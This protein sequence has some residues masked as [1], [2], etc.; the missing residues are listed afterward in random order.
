MEGRL[1]KDPDVAASYNN[2]LETCVTKGYVKKVQPSE[3]PKSKWY[4]PHFPIVKPDRQTTKTRIVFDAA[5]RYKDVALNDFINPSPKLQNDLVNVLLRFR[6]YP[7]ALVCDIAKMYLRIKLPEGDRAYHRFLWRELQTK[8][9]DV[10]EFQR[11]VFGV[12]SSPFQAQFVARKNAEINIDF[13]P[14]AADTVLNSTYMDDSMDS[15]HDAEKGIALF[16]ELHEL[17]GKTDMH[18]RIWMSNSP[19]IMECIPAE[20]GAAEMKVPTGNLPDKKV[21]GLMWVASE[22]VFTFVYSV[23]AYEESN[24]TH[25]TERNCFNI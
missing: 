2:T 21:L 6:R 20:L 16:K 18:A 9:P 12:N 19:K 17:W 15:V 13:F 23:P 25:S 24:Q 1:K 3:I 4:L 5:A 22:D 8:P 7:V 11:V 14:E 10:Y